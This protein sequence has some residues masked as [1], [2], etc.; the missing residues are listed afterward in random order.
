VLFWVNL[1][2][3]FTAE[4]L[5]L[6]ETLEKECQS[7][8]DLTLLAE[9]IANSEA[10]SQAQA[11]AEQFNLLYFLHRFDYFCLQWALKVQNEIIRSGLVAVGSAGRLIIGAI[12]ALFRD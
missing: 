9:S 6:D 3:A 1:S 2:R 7:D 4:L 12:G 5:L 11:A 8:T 10:N